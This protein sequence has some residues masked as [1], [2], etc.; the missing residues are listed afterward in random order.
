[1]ALT[2]DEDFFSFLEKEDAFE[3]IDKVIEKSLLIK[4]YVVERD[5]KESSLRKVLNFGHT[6]GH[7]I[8]SEKS[9]SLYHG[10]CVALGMLPMC[11]DEIRARLIN[12]LS[13]AGL[14]VSCDVDM[15]RVMEA[16]AHDK[17][18]SSDGIDCVTVEK[19][20]SYVIEKLSGP[21]IRA[22]AEKIFSSEG[23]R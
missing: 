1:M 10:E 2:F 22:R 20:G 7:G 19:A 23:K 21:E 18:S 6:I 17:K 14:P 3:N 5:E 4:K 13:R 16:V 8:E 9:P 11:S 12:V 15:D